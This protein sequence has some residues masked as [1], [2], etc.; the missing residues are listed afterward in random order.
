VYEDEHVVAFEDINPLAP[1]HV[2]IVPRAHVASLDDAAG[3]PAGLEVAVL[4]AAREIARGRG[5]AASGWR[6][7]ANSGPDAGQ[8]VEHLH[9]HLIGGRK[10][11]PMC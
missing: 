5:V 8:E 4:R 6:L 3:A 11:G 10:L 2:L 1:V 9:F 7:V